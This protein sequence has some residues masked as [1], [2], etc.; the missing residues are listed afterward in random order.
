MKISLETIALLKII[1]IGLPII[2]F[3]VYKIYKESRQD[4]VELKNYRH[5]KNYK[6]FKRLNRKLRIMN[7]D[8]TYTRT[9]KNK[10]SKRN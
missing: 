1:F 6:Y 9:S 8:K 10:K 5:S 7:S 4:N 2:L 3:I